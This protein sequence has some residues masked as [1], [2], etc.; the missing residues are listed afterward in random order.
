MTAS[1]AESPVPSLADR[2]AP[3]LAGAEAETEI[4]LETSVSYADGSPVRIRVRRR[5]GKLDIDDLGG[6]VTSVS[7][8]GD[9]LAAARR[10]VDEDSLNVNR[11]GVVFVQAFSE[12]TAARLAP[13]VAEASRRLELALIDAD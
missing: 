7:P 5:S 4:V 9:W 12:E 11:R 13:R 1:R 2:L 6:A 3:A 8:A 10:S